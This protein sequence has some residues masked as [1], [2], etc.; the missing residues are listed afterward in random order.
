[1]G[2][3][4]INQAR[5]LCGSLSPVLEFYEGS[6]VVRFAPHLVTFSQ[7]V[8][9]LLAPFGN[10]LLQQSNVLCRPC[11]CDAALRGLQV[12]QVYGCVVPQVDRIC[13]ALLSVYKKQNDIFTRG[14]F[15]R[16]RE[17]L[18]HALLRNCTYAPRDA[19]NVSTS[20]ACSAPHFWPSARAG[21]IT[22]KRYSSMA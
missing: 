7:H 1:M 2:F 21:I 6:G 10:Q 20:T 19:M 4:L 5:K 8:F 13:D 11:I 22:A 17:E 16:A 3:N 15:T 9:N 12:I 18:R 14:N